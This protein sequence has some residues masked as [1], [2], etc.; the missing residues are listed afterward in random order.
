[1]KIFI[2]Q[3]KEWSNYFVNV[4]EQLKVNDFIGTVSCI[5]IAYVEPHKRE[6]NFCIIVP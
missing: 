6:I 5:Y 4:K 3:Q 2:Y 1:M